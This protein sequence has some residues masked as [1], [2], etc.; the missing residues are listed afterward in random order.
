[1]ED[2]VGTK[3]NG[4]FPA[5]LRLLG[6]FSVELKLAFGAELRY[7]KNSRHLRLLPKSL[8]ELRISLEFPT[9]LL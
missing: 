8:A 7:G 3:A 9:E 5:K 6:K 1:M 4:K 2:F